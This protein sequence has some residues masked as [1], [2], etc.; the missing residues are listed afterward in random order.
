MVTAIR[1]LRFVRLR[2]EATVS[3]LA[4]ILEYASDEGSLRKPYAGNPLTLIMMLRRR[5][6]CVNRSQ[7]IELV[8][9][10]VFISAKRSYCMQQNRKSNQA[11]VPAP[12][13]LLMLCLRIFP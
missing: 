8:V 11:N 13:F 2:S 12:C 1:E 7:G 5:M 9:H 3:D 10:R 4:T 6:V